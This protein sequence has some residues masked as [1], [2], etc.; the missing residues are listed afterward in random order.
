MLLA[1]L[2]TCV[3]GQA[4]KACTCRHHVSV[5]RETNVH[6]QVSLNGDD[7][8]RQYNNAPRK[9]EVSVPAVEGQLPSKVGSDV[10]ESYERIVT[11]C[12]EDDHEWS[13]LQYQIEWSPGVRSLTHFVIPS[14]CICLLTLHR[15]VVFSGVLLGDGGC[16]PQRRR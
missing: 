10:F 7:A 13:V 16:V 4:C 8:R 6:L 1:L 14:I 12:R 2:L 5:L 3:K 15:Y 9:D 11:H